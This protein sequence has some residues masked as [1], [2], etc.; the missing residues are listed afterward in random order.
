M[1][2]NTCNKL[3]ECGLHRCTKICHSGNCEMCTEV[4]HQECYCGKVG[5][6]VACC[7][8]Y[9]GKG[10]YECGEVCGKQLSCGNHTCK[11]LCLD[12]P[13]EICTTDIKQIFTCH[14]GKTGLEKKRTSCLD[15]IHCCDKVRCLIA[16]WSKFNISVSHLVHV[17]CMSNEEYVQI[18]SYIFLCAHTYTVL[19]RYTS[20]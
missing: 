12:G 6:K 16:K 10:N 13:C 3:L 11:K 2:N 19:F 18:F 5:R 8:Q 9:R 17:I 15:P 4:I 1:C 14:C 20:L 7:A